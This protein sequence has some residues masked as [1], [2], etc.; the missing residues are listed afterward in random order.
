MQWQTK[1]IKQEAV[2]LYERNKDIFKEILYNEQ[3]GFCASCGEYKRFNDLTIDHIVPKTV[4]NILVE[5]DESTIALVH[6]KDNLQLVCH[7][8]NSLKGVK[9]MEDL[10]VKLKEEN[11]IDKTTYNGKKE[12]WQQFRKQKTEISRLYNQIF[13]KKITT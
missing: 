5:N 8:D 7:R 4:N 6:S 2:R 1:Q 13:P 10:L 9:S 11:L 12:Y 3:N